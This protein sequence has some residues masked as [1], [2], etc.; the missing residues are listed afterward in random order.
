MNALLERM[1]VEIDQL[2]RRVAVLE[3]LDVVKPQ[4]RVYS[5]A[6]QSLTSSVLTALTFTNARWDLPSGHF[7]LSSPTRLTCQIAGL[8]VAFGHVGFAASASGTQRQIN[9]MLNG[10]T[11]IARASEQLEAGGSSGNVHRLIV[12]TLWRFAVADYIELQAYQD[13]GGAL[14]TYVE[15]DDS[16][17][18][19]FALI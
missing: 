10:S 17:E 13:T 11:Y 14:N 19:A 16:P 4:A 2:R 3:A 12:A 9:I 1:A 7:S 5:T 8:Y 15:A 6:A 18:F